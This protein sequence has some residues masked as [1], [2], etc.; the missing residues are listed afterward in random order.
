MNGMQVTQRFGKTPWS[1]RYSSG[2]H[3]G[4]DMYSSD[5]RIYAPADGTFIRGVQRC[6]SVSLNYAAI[7]HGNGVVSYYLHIK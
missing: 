3:T 1:W 4:V 2:I 7:D 5:T 6:Y